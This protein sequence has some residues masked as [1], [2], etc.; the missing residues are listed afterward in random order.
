MKLEHLHSHYRKIKDMLVV[1]LQHEVAA[2]KW[3]LVRNIL[4]NIQ[5]LEDLCN[6]IKIYCSDFKEEEE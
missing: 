5:E 6:E 3:F 2:E 4:K 1:R